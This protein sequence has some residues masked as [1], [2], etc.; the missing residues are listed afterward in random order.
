[1]SWFLKFLE[2]VL[3]FVV[4]LVWCGADAL[5]Q[6]VERLSVT[7]WGAEP[8][9]RHATVRRPDQSVSV[10][11]R[12]IAFGSTSDELVPG[13][14]GHFSIFLHD[15]WTREIMLA[16]RRSDGSAIS[17]PNNYPA[18]TPDGRFLAFLSDD[19]VMHGVIGV[20][21]QAYVKDLGSGLVRLVSQ[22]PQ[23]RPG[24]YQCLG[25]PSISDDG[26]YVAF[27]SLASNLV[28]GDTNFCE[29][30]FVR[31]LVN[32]TTERI[33]LSPTGQQGNRASVAPLIAGDG[34]SIAY[35]TVSTN[36]FPN[37]PLNSSL[38]MW[39]DLRNGQTLCFSLDQNGQ[40]TSGGNGG[41]FLSP[42]GRLAGFLSQSDVFVPGDTNQR[43]DLFVRDLQTWQIE[44]VSVDSNGNQGNRD[45]AGG[46]LSRDGRFVVFKS[47]ATNW[48]SGR[49]ANVLYLHD[50][51][52][53]T[54]R[55]VCEDAFGNPADHISAYGVISGDGRVVA[56]DS[57]ATNLVPDD[58]NR[59]TDFFVRDVECPSIAGAYER[60]CT[61]SNGRIP[62]V[63]LAGCPSAGRDIALGVKG[64]LPNAATAVIFGAQRGS[65]PLDPNGCT[66]LVDAFFLSSTLLLPTDA[67]GSAHLPLRIPAS[68]G[69]RGDFTLQA[70][71]FDPGTAS[72]LATTRGIDVRM[73]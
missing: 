55:P 22:T 24:N 7:S 44:R 63:Y 30:I 71:V 31:D 73:R 57:F 19:Q 45:C 62:L 64:T 29:D 13:V 50:R 56:F 23:G 59:E 28:P 25:A 70:L 10:D 26:R 37:Q 52:T 69:L 65:F 33:S 18:L 46:S 51:V 3:V 61:G 12:W 39:R 67:E 15:C 27:C 48:F 5:S 49:P 42:D 6:T 36:F 53:R 8:R 4:A 32:G 11:G 34:R 47:E 16:S 35:T 20:G 66:V 9:A 54:T 2:A 1:M 21:A 14:G 40:V 60:G 41:V 72:G 43:F 38:A 68:P 17:M 58:T